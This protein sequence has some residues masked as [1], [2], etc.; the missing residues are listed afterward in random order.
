MTCNVAMCFTWPT[1]EGMVSENE[2]PRRLQ[3]MLGIYNLV[4][5]AGGAT[6]YFVA[7]AL[8]E[9]FGLRILFVV[10]ATIHLVNL[11]LTL[12]LEKKSGRSP[13]IRPVDGPEKSTVSSPSGLLRSPVSPETFLKMAWLANPFAYLAV[14][15]VIAV[16][17][18]MARH[19]GL[20]PRY[21][22][23]FCSIWLFV[24]AASFAALWQW[25]GWHYRFRW[26]ATA[27]AA[28]VAGFTTIL[29]APNLA[30][31]IAAQ[32]AFG[33]AL[34]LIYYS[35]LYYSMDV[36]ETKGEHGGFHEAAIGAGNFAGP[37]IGA[38]ALAFFPGHENS[39]AW[40]VSGCLL[41]GL[42]GLVWLRWKP[43]PPPAVN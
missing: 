39:S 38:T 10:P 18:S 17:P 32:L 11:G 19:L 20:S 27:Y 35:S 34:G 31:L 24:R 6:A 40:A 42:V 43:Q 5:A 13:A 12:F 37:A 7:G 1:L 14:N 21:V 30:V 33:L 28:M 16:I 41:L 8:I 15:T 22:G 2:P 36:G 29:L 26:L 3:K 25:P 23:F 9:R 4:W